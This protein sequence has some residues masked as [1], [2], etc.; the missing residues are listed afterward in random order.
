MIDPPQVS[1]L[2][3]RP[4]P[5][6]SG[7]PLVF[8]RLVVLGLL[9]AAVVS[10]HL[11]LR[12]GGESPAGAFMMNLSTEIVGIGITVAIVDWLLE[13]RTKWEESRRIAWRVLHEL[14]YAVW[15]WQGGRR[16]LISDELLGLLA[17]TQ[18]DDPLPAFTENLLLRIGSGAEFT[19][20][21]QAD[22]VAANRHLENGLKHLSRLSSIRDA[23]GA[24]DRKRIHWYLHNATA[25]LA[26]ALDLKLGVAPKHEIRRVRDT[27]VHAQE[28]RRFGQ[29]RRANKPR[30]SEDQNGDS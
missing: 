24:Y 27:S 2:P 17:E 26:R 18:K 12:I 23:D 25:A 28:M 21:H 9:L 29:R 8:R 1:I 16:E 10:I 20:Q 11:A 3:P 30:P 13:R 6:H 14:D 19:C 7:E 4:T 5:E 22:I 15:V